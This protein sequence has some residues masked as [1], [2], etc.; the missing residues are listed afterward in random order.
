MIKDI[1]EVMGCDGINIHRG[2]RLRCFWLGK[3]FSEIYNKVNVADLRAK[4][5]T[6]RLTSLVNKFIRVLKSFKFSEANG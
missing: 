4:K 3:S 2:W 6:K 1:K 5:G